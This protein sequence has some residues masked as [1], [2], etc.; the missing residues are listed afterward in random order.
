MSPDLIDSV[1]L[2]RTVNCLNQ[3]LVASHKA[4]KE[5]QARLQ[6][7]DQVDGLLKQVGGDDNDGAHLHCLLEGFFSNLILLQFLFFFFF[8]PRFNLN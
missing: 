7:L 3:E 6:E 1:E 5:L 8:K 2:E 4:E